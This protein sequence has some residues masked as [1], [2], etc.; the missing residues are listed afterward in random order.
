MSSFEL[1]FTLEVVAS[2]HE[3]LEA[4]AVRALA[5][6][7]HMPDM[8]RQ[9]AE[10]DALD[11]AAGTTVFLCRD[12]ATGQA[13]GT[14][15][16]Q[17]STYGPLLM[18]Q[19]LSLPI[20][21]ASDTR[22]EVTR[23]A[24]R[25]GADPLTRLALWKA[26]YQFCMANGLHWMAVGARNEALIRNYRRLGFIDVFEHDALMPLAHTGGLPHR[27]MAF[28]NTAAYWRWRESRHPL[29]HFFV[30]TEHVEL[31]ASNALQSHAPIEI[32]PGGQPQP[33][34]A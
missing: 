32:G 15:R 26:S 1:G 17:S 33:A 5:Y 30:E 16:M 12:K 4:C 18:E 2:Q 19:S 8:G 20:W 25:V 31:A 9:L 24:V 28:D 23:L 7:H 22:A 10:P 29:Y 34:L 27:I 3:L 11:Y 6:G 21:L 13:T 14:M